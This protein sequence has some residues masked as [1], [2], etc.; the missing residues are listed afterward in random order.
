MNDP[1][2]IGA[3]ALCLAAYLLG[4]VNAALAAAKLRGVD[5][6]AEGSGNPGASNVFRVLGP[7]PAAAV[8]TADL[9]KGFLP[10]LAGALM[11][12]QATGALA[13][14]WAVIGHCYPV[15]H[16]FR[17]GKGAAAGGG[18]VLA[19]APLAML[20]MAAVYAAGLKLSRISAVGALAAAAAAP[21]ALLLAGVDAW[22]VGWCGATAALIVWRHRSNL[23]RLRAGAEHK[24]L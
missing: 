21:P 22:A 1:N 20:A 10:A 14:L 8:Y 5:I 4:S 23:M 13:G 18:A 9:A 3:A 11:W 6:R 2:V 16:R 12:G 19:L 24:L 17:G 15:F 7:G